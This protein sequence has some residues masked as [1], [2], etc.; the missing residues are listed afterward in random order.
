MGRAGN[1]NRS[2]QSVDDDGAELDTMIKDY[3]VSGKWSD[4]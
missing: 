1:G 3:L 2:L 4:Q